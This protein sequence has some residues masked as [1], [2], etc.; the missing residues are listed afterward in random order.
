MARRVG[1]TPAAP[2]SGATSASMPAALSRCAGG[3][4]NQEKSRGQRGARDK[5]RTD[6]I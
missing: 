2:A 6:S 1:T 3:P 5:C 4:R